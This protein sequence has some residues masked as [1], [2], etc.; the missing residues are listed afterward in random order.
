MAKHHL[1]PPPE[2]PDPHPTIT[3]SRPPTVAPVTEPPAS[4]GETLA[5]DTVTPDDNIANQESGKAVENDVKERLD[6]YVKDPNDEFAHCPDVKPRDPRLEQQIYGVQHISGMNFVKYFDKCDDIPFEASGHDAPE[7]IED[8]QN[9]TLDELAKSNVALAGYVKPTQLQKHSVAIVTAGR[10]LMAFKTSRTDLPPTT[11]PATVTRTVT[12]KSFR[13]PWSYPR[14]RVLQIYE[15][16]RKFAY[17][18]WVRPCVVYGIKSIT[19]QIP[20]RDRGCDLLITTPGCLVDLIERGRVSLSSVRYL[21]LDET[22]RMLDMG[23]EPQIRRLVEKE[24]MPPPSERQT[25]MFSATFHRNIIPDNIQML[26][27]DVLKDYIFLGRD[28]STLETAHVTNRQD[29]ERAAANLLKK[30]SR[31]IIRRRPLPPPK[32]KSLPPLPPKTVKPPTTP[33]AVFRIASVQSVQ[34][35]STSD[36]VRPPSRAG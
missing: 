22:D 9:S 28:R 5:K 12:A 8:F 25:L 6:G 14:P 3:H 11:M 13:P 23:F 19:Y 36:S 7:A 18:S 15:E 1:T 24:D 30:K 26:A 21:I 31:T 20:D 29:S 2:P 17:R 10:D 34:E 27:R 32:H 4:V 16:A 33:E 35:T